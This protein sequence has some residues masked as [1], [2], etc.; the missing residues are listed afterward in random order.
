[1]LLILSMRDLKPEFQSRLLSAEDIT[2][3]MVRE[4]IEKVIYSCETVLVTDSAGLHHPLK[5]VSQRVPVK[6]V[7]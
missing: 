6:A 5:C 7:G 3:D 1:M 2:T 4:G